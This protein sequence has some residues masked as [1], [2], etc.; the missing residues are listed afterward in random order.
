M[1]SSACFFLSV[2]IIN[3]H[4]PENCLIKSVSYVSS[5]EIVLK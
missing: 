1:E 4:L 2:L 5:S 3:R